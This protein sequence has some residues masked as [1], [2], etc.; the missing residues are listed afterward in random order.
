VI[1]DAAQAFGAS[2]ARGPVGCLGTTGCFSFFPTK[3]L[4]ALGD[5]GLVVTNDG[6]LA[7]RLRMLRVQG[8]QS[9]YNHVLVGGNF[10]LDALQAA[11][12][13]AKLPHEPELTARRRSHA[14][15]YD[16]AFAELEA[17]GHVRRPAAHAGH[18][19]HQ[20]V[21]RA[22]RRDELRRHL[23]AARIET[24]RY[25]PAPLHRMPVKGGAVDG[26]ALPHAEAAC[27]ENLALP[28]H[29]WLSDA[30]LRRISREVS[31]FF[32]ARHE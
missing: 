2:T 11:F 20:Y 6:A 21:L 27:R 3:N 28:V 7:E 25:Y 22:D 8:A 16:A 31:G 29:P 1:E 19:Y 12:L 17:A 13:D 30:E 18:V 9:R 10:R 32:G 15:V 14:A 23:Q 4:G 26:P 24:G 5:G